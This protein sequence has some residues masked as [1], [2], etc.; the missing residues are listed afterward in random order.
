MDA[1]IT[2][3]TRDGSSPSKDV[4]GFCI[5]GTRLVDDLRNLKRVSTKPRPAKNNALWCACTK[6]KPNA[7]C[8]YL[9]AN[10]TPNW[11][12]HCDQ[13]DSIT[14]IVYVTPQ[15]AEFLARF[16]TAHDVADA[17]KKWSADGCAMRNPALSAGRANAGKAA[18]AAKSIANPAVRSFDTADVADANAVTTDNSDVF[19]DYAF[20]ANTIKS[21]TLTSESG[22]EQTE[23]GTTSTVVDPDNSD[24]TADEV[25]VD[26][27]ERP[28]LEKVRVV[29]ADPDTVVNADPVATV[30]IDDTDDVDEEIVTLNAARAAVTTLAPGQFERNG[31]V[32]EFLPAINTTVCLDNKYTDVHAFCASN[33]RH[34]WKYVEN[35][36]ARNTIEELEIR[37]G[38]DKGSLIE[39]HHMGRGGHATVFVHPA[40]FLCLAQWISPAKHAEVALVYM[41]YSEG[42][43]T[44][45]K[46]ILNRFDEANGTCT[47]S[48]VRE[49]QA[50]ADDEWVLHQADAEL[51]RKRAQEEN[52][53]RER[54]L[55]KVR[56]LDDYELQEKECNLR[57]LQ[58]EVQQKEKE[59][60]IRVAKLYQELE[61]QKNTDAQ[62]LEIRK[63]KDTHDLRVHQFRDIKAAFESCLD[64]PGVGEAERGVYRAHIHNAVT[65]MSGN[66]SGALA[67]A[68]SAAPIN[69]T[70]NNNNNPTNNT[71]ITTAVQQCEVQSWEN[72]WLQRGTR[73]NN[74]VSISA[75]LKDPTEA[76]AAE[77]KALVA[78]DPQIMKSFGAKLAE[79]WRGAHI[80][81]D[82]PKMERKV[83]GQVRRVAQY[84]EADRPLMRE[85]IDTFLDN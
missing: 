57:R 22:L 47:R 15:L 68:P 32:Y 80:G 13:I 59:M 81:K 43:V 40:L 18:T 4:S 72:L 52:A 49:G 9:V 2:L 41:R 37:L 25:M 61:T 78:K 11:R 39:R 66:A 16:A 77:Y 54:T 31:K 19:A 33:G 36:H 35:V 17:I 56:K 73:V 63:T 82:L 24:A 27:A 45:A 69:V 53:E 20:T 46:D 1:T 67:I 12:S 83:A 5:D 7:L 28:S 42:D 60:E 58:L 75:F 8:A 44:L 79:A 70:V 50:G 48:L 23:R 10:F 29:A 21:R 6:T 55:A 30:A 74:A 76:K 71:D 26:A 84:Y 65:E 85:V 62:E 3:C 34:W 51:T 64:I 14:K 38:V